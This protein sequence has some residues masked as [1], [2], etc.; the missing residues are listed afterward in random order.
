LLYW[1]S[2]V[3]LLV[4]RGILHEDPVLFTLSDCVSYIC[5]VLILLL[6]L[7]SVGGLTFI[8]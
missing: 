6:I 1:I 2:R 8:L 3:W 7:I 4:Q 5:G